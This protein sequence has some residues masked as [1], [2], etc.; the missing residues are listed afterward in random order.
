MI[1]RPRIG[2][3]SFFELLRKSQKGRVAEMKAIMSN[4]VRMND[5]KKARRTEMT[6]WSE[7]R[8][9]EFGYEF[10]TVHGIGWTEITK[11]GN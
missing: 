10:H 1:R 9:I 3:F 7:T 2:Q 4:T 6:A 11:V 5:I 8:W